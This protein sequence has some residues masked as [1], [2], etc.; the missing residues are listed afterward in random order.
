MHCQPF[1][2]GGGTVS[3]PAPVS[4]AYARISWFTKWICNHILRDFEEIIQRRLLWLRFSVWKYLYRDHYYNAPLSWWG[5]K[6]IARNVC[7]FDVG[8]DC[9]TIIQE[10][11]Q[12]HVNWSTFLSIG[13]LRHGMVTNYYIASDV[14]IY[15][16]N[17]CWNLLILWTLQNDL[18]Q[19]SFC[20]DTS[21]RKCSRS[22]LSLPIT[23]RLTETNTNK[24]RETYL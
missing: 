8:C 3:T 9:N 10:V 4:Y 2:W 12:V 14:F 5:E 16:I 23:K 20:I 21:I 15:R 13:S 22:I 17:T 24:H 1:F 11:K 7:T 19:V 6:S 18:I